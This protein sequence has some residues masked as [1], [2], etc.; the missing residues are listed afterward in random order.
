MEDLDIVELLDIQ[1]NYVKSE[2]DKK[3]ASHQISEPE[4]N[5]NIT[6]LAYEYA[7]YGMP[8]DCLK[9]LEFIKSDYFNNKAIE[10]FEQDDEYFNKAV[11]IFEVLSFIGH[12]PYDIECTQSEA[13]A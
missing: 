8:E 12:I 4:Y 6:I 2:L 13:K 10:H 9:M 3:L 1:S 7:L 11:L 5:K